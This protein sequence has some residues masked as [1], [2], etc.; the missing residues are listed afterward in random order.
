LY[1]YTYASSSIPFNSS[2]SN[3][4]EFLLYLDN[5]YTC[6]NDYV[7]LAIANPNLPLTTKYSY[8]SGTT[9]FSYTSL[10]A[11]Y[12]ATALYSYTTVYAKNVLINSSTRKIDIF[13]IP[14]TTIHVSTTGLP[15][16]ASQY[17][18]VYDYTYKKLYVY[19]NGDWQEV[20]WQDYIKRDKIYRNGEIR[21]NSSSGSLEYYLH[22]YT[23]IEII[24]TIGRRF[25]YTKESNW[26]LYYIAPS[27]FCLISNTNVVTN[28]FKNAC[29]III[30][31]TY[32]LNTV[33][34]LYTDVYIH[35]YTD[36]E[37]NLGFIGKFI[38]TNF[39]N[40]ND[41]SLKTFKSNSFIYND[42]IIYNPMIRLYDSATYTDNS[43]VSI[44]FW[45]NTDLYCYIKKI[46]IKRLY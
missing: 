22:S 20:K 23:W 29:D 46:I 31:V 36:V 14:Y 7:N 32:P 30:R 5:N 40:I 13:D 3:Q 28:I 2:A 44:G 16:T 15:F 24:P 10:S 11:L 18:S 6:I 37:I 42:M 43:I 34:N 45:S 12:S 41:L 26:Y 17:D 25:T 39:Y 9:R 8:T 21:I 19:I 1:S 4:P 27:Q 38:K 35:S 33:L